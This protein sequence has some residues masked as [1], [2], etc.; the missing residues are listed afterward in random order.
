MKGSWTPFTPV[1]S[2]PH[3]SALAAICSRHLKTWENRTEATK[4]SGQGLQQLLCLRHTK[5]AVKWSITGSLLKIMSYDLIVCE[6]LYIA[7]CLR[8]SLLFMTWISQSIH[9]KEHECQVFR[10][11]LMSSNLLFIWK[12]WYVIFVIPYQL[13]SSFETHGQ[14]VR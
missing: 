4:S 8:D 7:V 5:G 11:L 9:K 10:T 14:P 6:I 3:P 12:V 1:Y 2:P 13:F